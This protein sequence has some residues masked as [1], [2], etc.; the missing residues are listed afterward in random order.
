[1]MKHEV[2]PPSLHCVEDTDYLDWAHSPFYVNK[3]IKPWPKRPQSRWGAVSA[4][5]MSG[6]NAHV[7]VQSLDQLDEPVNAE[8]GLDVLLAL[9]AKTA[10]ALQEKAQ[11]LI[12][13]LQSRPWSA[14]QLRAMSLTLLAGR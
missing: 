9:S 3:Q 14:H 1:A 4:F 2:I 12:Q 7:V 13:V 8:D 6:T 11:D 10:S 5:G